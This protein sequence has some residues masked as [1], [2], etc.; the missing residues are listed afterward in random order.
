MPLEDKT[1][2]EINSTTVTPMMASAVPEVAAEAPEAPEEVAE[3][4][5]SRTPDVVEQ[6]LNPKIEKWLH[7]YEFSRPIV[8]INC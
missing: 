8:L 4:G 5:S 1:G 6:L 3:V 2:R 7:A